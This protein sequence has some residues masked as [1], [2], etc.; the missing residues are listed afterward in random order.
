M[1]VRSERCLGG[2]HHNSALS[3]ARAVV[4]ALS[5]CGCSLFFGYETKYILCI[6]APGSWR[7]GIRRHAR[8]VSA[9]APC[10]AGRL[11]R[12]G[13]GGLHGAQ[14][15]LGGHS[16]HWR[17]IAADARAEWQPGCPLLVECHRPPPR[18]AAQP[19]GSAQRLVFVPAFGAHRGAHRGAS[20]GAVH[21]AICPGP[22]RVQSLLS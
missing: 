4:F 14:P 22:W 8:R 6:A 11:Q 19:R 1:Q 15:Q 5:L 17:R 7:C 18:R 21:G 10:G 9:G 16:R 20:R 3:D 12:A 2:S 13:G